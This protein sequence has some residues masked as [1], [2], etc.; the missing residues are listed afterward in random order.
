MD[1]VSTVG[2]GDSTLAGYLLGLTGGR[3]PSAALAQAVAYGAAA[4]GLRG[5][6]VP[7]PEDAR[8]DAVTV[9]PLE[10]TVA[11]PAAAPTA[12]AAAPTDDSSHRHE[13]TVP[14]AEEAR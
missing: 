5:T 10:A 6:G 4:A 9:T 1:V 12:Q 7:S 13:G 14:E 2:A 8:T 11:A 3:E